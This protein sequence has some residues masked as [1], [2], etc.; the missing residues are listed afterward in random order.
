MAKMA[1]GVGFNFPALML[2]GPIQAKDSTN[3][4]ASIQNFS[5]LSLGINLGI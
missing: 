2:Q 4:V 5:Q 3:M 1:K